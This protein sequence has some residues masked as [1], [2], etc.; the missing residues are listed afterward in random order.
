MDR[1]VSEI[2]DEEL[3]RRVISRGSQRLPGRGRREPLWSYVS[4]QFCLGSTYSQQLCRRFGYDPDQPGT[5]RM[6]PSLTPPAYM[7]GR[8]GIGTSRGSALN[9]R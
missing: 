4:Y 7:A 1:N 8:G 2:A 3:I 9:R 6:T 5:P